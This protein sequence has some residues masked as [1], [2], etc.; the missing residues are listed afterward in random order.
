[1]TTSSSI[2]PDPGLPTQSVKVPP[3]WMLSATFRLGDE[4]AHVNRD[5]D[6]PP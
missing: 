5:A 4:E 6:P 3:R 1:M 2:L